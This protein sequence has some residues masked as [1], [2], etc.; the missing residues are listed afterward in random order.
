MEPGPNLAPFSKKNKIE[1]KLGYKFRAK[2]ELN[3]ILGKNKIQVLGR[4]RFF[5]LLPNLPWLLFFARAEPP[6]TPKEAWQ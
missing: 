5:L 2:L 6:S 1:L 3:S 4:L